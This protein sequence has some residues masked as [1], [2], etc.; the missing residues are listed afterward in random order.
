MFKAHL[1][2]HL[3]VVAVVGVW[4]GVDRSQA[5]D[6]TPICPGLG[7]PAIGTEHQLLSDS[8]WTDAKGEASSFGGYGDFH[9]GQCPSTD[10]NW[11]TDKPY[12]WDGWD[13]RGWKDPTGSVG[14]QSVPEPA[15]AMMMAMAGLGILF[16]R[17]RKSPDSGGRVSG[18]GGHDVHGRA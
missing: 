13:F 7:D 6:F 10:G 18:V 4:L 11:N 16:R 9:H 3:I 14:T 2:V 5:A 8:D 17:R 15:S 1:S 12:D